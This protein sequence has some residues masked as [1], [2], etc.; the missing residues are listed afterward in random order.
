MATFADLKKD[1]LYFQRLLKFAG[2][3]EGNLDGKTGPLTRAAD[4]AWQADHAYLAERFGKFCDRTEA[5]LLTVVP[6]L[7][8]NIRKLLTELRSGGDDW[9]LTCGTRTAKEQTALYAQGRS[10]PGAKVTNA[11]AWKSYH[12]FGMAVDF[13]LFLDGKPVWDDKYYSVLGKLS[14]THGLFWGG[15]FHSFV[16]SPHMQLGDFTCLYLHNIFTGGKYTVADIM[17]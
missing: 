15:D 8:L 10:K 5:H 11:C 2:F 1:T 4:K 6:M 3:Y 17:R 13:V 12:N 7:A 14:K 9:V 16:D